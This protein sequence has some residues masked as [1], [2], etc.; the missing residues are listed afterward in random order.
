VVDHPQL[1]AVAVGA[2]GDAH[3]LAGGG[4]P[5]RVLDQV[6]DHPLEQR[7]VGD[8]LGQIG[9]HVHLNRVVGT[10]LVQRTRDHVVETDGCTQYRQHSGLQ[11]R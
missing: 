7:A 9:R 6:S 4:I 5:R 2:A 1:D 8:H 11:P 3:R 10:R